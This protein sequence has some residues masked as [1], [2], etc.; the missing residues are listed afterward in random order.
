MSDNIRKSLP[1]VGHDAMTRAAHRIPF[2]AA[3]VAALLLAIVPRVALAQTCEPT[4]LPGEGAP[5]AGPTYPNEVSDFAVYDDGNGPALYMG[6]T[7][8]YAGNERISNEVNS[9]VVRWDGSTFSIIGEVNG[10]RVSALTVYDGKLIVGGGFSEVDG[11]SAKDVAA[12]DGSQ[13]SA[14]GTGISGGANGVWDLFV[15][16][17]KLIATGGFNTAGGVPAANIAQ[18]DGA[19][20]SPLGPGIS[21]TGRALTEFE[22]DLAVGGL[23]VTAGGDTVHRVA[24]WDGAAW[25]AFGGGLISSNVYALTTFDMDGAGPDPAR[26]VAGGSFSTASGIDDL[27]YWNGT[28]WLEFEGGA[29]AVGS[30]LPL[31]GELIV[32]GRFSYVGGGTSNP[33]ESVARWTPG[34]GWAPLGVGLENG[35]AADVYALAEYA[36][37]IFAGGDFDYSGS[38]SMLHV[39]RWDGAEWRA[40][41]GG[42]G[43]SGGFTAVHALLPYGDGVVVGGRFTSVGDAVDANDIALRTPSGWSAFGAGLGEGND[44]G[45]TGS[46][47]NAL[48]LHNGAIHAAWYDFDSS[49]SRSHVSY[50]DGAAWNSIGIILSG[51]W[52]NALHSHGGDLFVAGSFTSMNSTLMNR[53]ARWDGASWSPLA[54]SLIG[55]DHVIN[56]LGSFEGDL[57]LGGRFSNAGGVAAS[58][59]AR[60]NGTEFSPMGA[61]FSVSGGATV[62]DF[63]IHDGALHAAHSNGIYRWDG[64]AWTRVVNATD[65]KALLSV[66]S[67]L[68]FAGRFS[69]AGGVTVEDVA[70]WDGV[71]VR[72]IGAG[73][74]PGGFGAYA[75]AQFA[76]GTIAVGHQEPLAGDDVSYAFARIDP[77]V[78]TAVGDPPMDDASPGG[79]SD[80]TWAGLEFGG[81]FT[82]AGGA[83]F[84]LSLPFAADAQL[85][86]YDVTGR[87]V[88]HW[89]DA[90]A[91]AGRRR[92]AL[93]DLSGASGAS[94]AGG[95]AASGRAPRA[96]ASGV[97]FGK[98]DVS[99]G[100]RAATRITRAIHIR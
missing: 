49:P 2:A 88:A 85:T 71:E 30:L 92:L 17:G 66:E 53:I 69:A 91:S 98:L 83:A 93:A 7:I 4:W 75:L 38:Q 22:G 65:V 34:S 28:T 41:S 46:A 12:W 73:L 84:S 74:G 20:W 50:W 29:F 80:A 61:G 35:S 78:A 23:F 100:A 18:W 6:G 59:V 47:V 99:A 64:A 27:A 82:H 55:V 9:A 56:A 89:R 67:D 72:A 79:A 52:F 76:D 8:D 26:L 25:S 36:G 43:G 40:L 11:V 60:W 51:N 86:V 13:W 10:A 33:A 62:Y 96:L 77:C 19:A 14:L 54:D 37:S 57:I 45:S 97:Y 90:N 70:R 31:G 15:H 81:V 48:A 68:Y 21:S 1:R 24:R 42:I 87:E 16:D 63:E 58:G 95:G 39:A 94:G 32:G 3:L 44:Q 5:G